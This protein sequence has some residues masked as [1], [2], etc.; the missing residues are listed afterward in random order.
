MVWFSNGLGSSHVLNLGAEVASLPH[1]TNS[2]TSRFNSI[3]YLWGM[4]WHWKR[5]ASWWCR[6]AGLLC[7]GGGTQML[8]TNSI[9][10]GERLMSVSVAQTSMSE[11]RKGQ[12]A[13]PFVEFNQTS[14]ALRV[15]CQI[16]I[17]GPSKQENGFGLAT[18][19]S[20]QNVFQLQPIQTKLVLDHQHHQ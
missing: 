8:G 18:L 14:A 2:G 12:E 7:L 10:V 17:H 11:C 16:R 6:L 1:D 5:E 19:A 15:V 20:V 9:C 4:M 3:T 13:L